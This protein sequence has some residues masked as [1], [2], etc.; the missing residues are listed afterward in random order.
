MRPDDVVMRPDLIVKA[1][2]DYDR[3]VPERPAPLARLLALLSQRLDR[4]M[5]DRQHHAG[6]DD[7]R[8]AHSAV[9][10]HVPPEG[11]RLSAL[12]CRAGMT[13]QAMSELVRD[14]ERLGYVAR[15]PDPTD[16]RSKLIEF[17]DRGWASVE[18]ALKTFDDLEAELGAELGAR[19]VSDMRRL[20]ERALHE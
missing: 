3:A 10:A 11:I 9:F 19:R 1:H 4:E 5:L 7:L 18:L 16:G 6:F 13:K 20:L 12:A 14:L 2:D 8:P 15:R 17:T